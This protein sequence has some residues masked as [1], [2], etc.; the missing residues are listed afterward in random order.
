[1]SCVI[2]ACWPPEGLAQSS[3]PCRPP[4]LRGRLCSWDSASSRAEGEDLILE[5]VRIVS[6]SCCTFNSAKMGVRR[7][8]SGW[9]VAGLR[10]PPEERV[11]AAQSCGVVVDGKPCLRILAQ[12][13]WDH[14]LGL[15]QVQG[16]RRSWAQPA[17][18]PF[19]AGDTRI[20][21]GLLVSATMMDG[22]LGRV[23]KLRLQLEGIV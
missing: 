3:R 4:H 20:V 10:G 16:N 11:P 15:S 18:S 23:R 22:D 13:G 17:R 21:Q 7:A 1:M 6:A 2:P 14:Y 5:D 12:G 9:A 8:S 19:E